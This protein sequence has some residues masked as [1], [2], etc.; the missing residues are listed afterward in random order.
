VRVA[1]IVGTRP[2]A[3]KMAPVIYQLRKRPGLFDA[4]IIATAQHRQMLDQALSLFNISPDYDLNLMYPG[5]SLSLLTSRVI[6]H[7]D[8]ALGKI[9]PDMVLV[10]GDTTTVLATAIAAFYRKIPVA[11]VEAGLRSYDMNNPFP[12]EANRRLTT[13]LTEINFAPTPLSRTMLLNEGISSEKIVVTGNTVVDS[14]Q[15]ILTKPFSCTGTPLEG[16]DFGNYRTILVTCHRRESLGKDLE[17][18]FLALID[19][20]REFPDIRIIY[21]VHLNPEVQSTAKRILSDIDR[22]HL[23]P[24]LDYLTFVNLM[25]RS[26]LILTD[27]GGLQEEA[28]TLAKPLFVLRHLTERPEA[29]QKGCSKVIGTAREAIVKETSHALRDATF[30]ST[31]ACA[32]NPYGDGKASLRIVEALERWSR[33]TLPLLEPEREFTCQD[34]NFT[35]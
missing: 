28:P 27:S 23:I 11:H 31:A 12:E 20:V 26:Y 29:F 32:G 17:E 1:V 8:L 14:L 35:L 5:Q 13:V 30:Y 18:I 16:I 25:K 6:D 7:M 9:K 2:E 4:V 24:P 33:G 22:I 19:L 34:C 3:I 15:Y 10:Q 21:P